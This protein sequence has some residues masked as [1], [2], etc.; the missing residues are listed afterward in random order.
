MGRWRLMPPGY[1]GDT[2]YGRETIPVGDKY[3]AYAAARRH[4]I[5][6]LR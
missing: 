3:Y 1:W 5:R 4:L 6:Q 2:A